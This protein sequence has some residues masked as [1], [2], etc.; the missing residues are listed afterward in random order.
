[1]STFDK[2]S[3][4][5]DGDGPEND[6]ADIISS[7]SYLPKDQELPKT[8][9]IKSEGDDATYLL[10]K[11]SDEELLKLLNDQP[12]KN[13]YDLRDIAKIASGF[14]INKEN[15]NFQ[16]ESAA[17]EVLDKDV[18]N[19]FPAKS[20][21]KQLSVKP[22]NE[23]KQMPVF[24]LDNKGISLDSNNDAQYLALKKLNSLLNYHSQSNQEDLDDDKKELLFNV[25]VN[26]LKTLCCKK[27]GKHESSK[28]QKNFSPSLKI[29]EK[30]ANEY[31][32]L[33]LND[34]IKSNGSDELILVDPE[35]LQQN[36]S[37]LLLGPI[38]TPLTDRQLKLIM[39]RIA[40]ELSKPEYLNL[41]R[42]L[43]DGTLDDSNLRILKNFIHGTETRRYIKP[44][45]CNHQSKLARVYGGPK[46]LICTGYINLNTP[47]LYD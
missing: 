23:N 44:H 16:G 19:Q 14:E 20:D 27:S 9:V 8:S 37:V 39:N 7:K 28:L 32:F 15:H 22:K 46:W 10:S 18:F 30:T 3:Y 31:M 17:F 25:L 43:S 11:L 2:H 4:F 42:Q 12:S 21:I 41:L 38:T 33:I 6:L 35:T 47:S 40:I 45:R 24:R 5:M 13:V 26:Q 1:M 29:K 36:S 34:E